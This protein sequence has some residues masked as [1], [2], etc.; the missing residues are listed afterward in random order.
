MGWNRSYSSTP[1]LA[2]SSEENAILN[3]NPVLPPTPLQITLSEIQTL[4]EDDV[5]LDDVWS[6]RLRAAAAGLRTRREG[7]I[8][9]E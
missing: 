6:E 9:S 8:A 4:L 3:Q 1:A 7:S 2:V 5:G